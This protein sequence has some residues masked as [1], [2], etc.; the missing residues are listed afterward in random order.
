MAVQER[1]GSYRIL[2]RYEGKQLAFAVGR[3]CVAEAKAKSSQVD[4]LLM[5][6]KQGLIVLPAGVDVVDFVRHDGSPP[7]P[8]PAP[9]LTTPKSPEPTLGFLRDRYL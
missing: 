6:L 5:R 4:Y 2:F 8:V 9:S 7:P 3:V 1:N